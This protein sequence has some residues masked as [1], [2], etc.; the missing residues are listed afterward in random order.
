MFPTLTIYSVSADLTMLNAILNGV[1]MIV[2]QTGFIWGFALL[3][4]T[5]NIIRTVTKATFA[6]VGGGGGSAMGTGA[7]DI[8]MPLIFASLLT[9]PGMKVSV[10][11]ES[12]IN[13]KL[14][15]VDNVPFVIAL[16]PAMASELSQ[17]LGGL[18]ETAY[19]SAGTNYSSISASGNGFVNPL[20]VLL[21]SRTAIMRL[22]SVDSQV[23]SVVGACINSD[24]G[25][26]YSS[27]IAKVMNAGNTGASIAESIPINGIPKTALGALLYQAS[28]NTTGLV[29][30]MNISSQSISTCA[31]AAY[32][33][34]DN[35]GNTLNSKE[36]SRVVQGAVNGSDQPN[37]NADYSFTKFAEQYTAVRTA[38]TSL[39]AL[40]DGTTQANAEA[41]NLLF[42]ELVT[43]DLNCLRSDASNKTTCQA[44]AIQ[45][46]EI[47]RNN[48]Q[49]AA[50][51]VQMLKYAG[52]FANHIMALIIGL[53]PVVVMFMMFSGSNA[54]KSIYTV[55]HIM[56]WPLLVLNVGAEIINGMIYMQVATF[57]T[58]I[59]Q[60][61]YLSQAVAIEAYKQ[62]SIQVGTASHIMSSLPVLMSMIFGLSATSAM[63]SVASRMSPPDSQAATATTPQAISTAPILQNSSLASAAQG[64]GYNTLA[65]TGA[66]KAVNQNAQ[67]GQLAQQAHRAQS[68]EA[69]RQKTITEG[70]SLT[71]AFTERGSLSN[72]T[73]SGIDTST[74]KSISNRVAET[75]RNAN[76][77]HVND[78]ASS[79]K[80]NSNST[81][82]GAGGSASASVG[83]GGQHGTGVGVGGS[84]RGDT[85]TTATDSMTRTQ[86]AGKSKSVEE[87]KAVEKAIGDELRTAKTNGSSTDKVKAL[88]AMY[89][90][91][92]QY[93]STLSESL[94]N[95]D[96]SGL[97]NSNTNSLVSFA[98]NY[99]SESL[100]H[101]IQTNKGMR[102]FQLTEG[103]NF[104]QSTAA[105]KHMRDASQMVDSGASDQV[106]MS[107]L[108]RQAAIRHNAAVRLFN[109]GNASADDRKMASDYLTKQGMAISGL[110]QEFGSTERLN[111]KVDR[112]E[113]QTEVDTR[114]LDQRAG[115][116]L[117]PAPQPT[118]VATSPRPAAPAKTTTAGS[119][120]PPPTPPS[121]T[122]NATL[123][124]VRD[125]FAKTDAAGL[126]QVTGDG[127]IKRAG[128]NVAGNLKNV[129]TGGTNERVEFGKLD[130]GKK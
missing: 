87:A 81:T 111:H 16:V 51:E 78:N 20:K 31:D 103:R 69:A 106:R 34:A 44:A 60:G 128:S 63:V 39:S 21:T 110:Q 98:Q 127:T 90:K 115:K 17:E 107:P 32:I 72:A 55:V 27:I 53:G 24:S 6:S 100:A 99:S 62:F 41:I 84:L 7:F 15:K 67:Y 76:S 9:A 28:L 75:M 129:F 56:V 5:W 47:E 38:N 11:L 23:K 70:E 1:A 37:P 48:I 113:D 50:N 118:A 82:L 30:D 59:T 77:E 130:D 79:S 116:L 52:S 49:R 122:V 119:P 10:N 105:A 33:V 46:L 58:S 109:D 85:A 86:T 68:E 3:V 123:P 4:S 80:S 117:S 108:A 35:I 45:G 93:T 22:G 64:A 120:P 95:K 121:G 112:P 57:L 19:Q 91:Q 92:Q 18:V 54:S 66:I 26:D 126:N 101:S 25:A 61:G 13:G 43:S 2:N 14:S 102:D 71:K 114:N 94:S 8:I 124:E 73:R 88:E 12:T 97:N 74:A 83:A 104:E 42:S 96:S 36:F 125:A 40:A 29:T 89:S 65:E